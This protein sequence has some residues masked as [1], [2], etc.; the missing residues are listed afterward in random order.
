M[1]CLY[2]GKKGLRDTSSGKTQEKDIIVKEVN[3]ITSID[4]S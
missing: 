2:P 1:E 3:F 4:L